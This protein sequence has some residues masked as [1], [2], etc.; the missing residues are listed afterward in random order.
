MVG[1]GASSAGAMRLPGAHHRVALDGAQPERIAA[2][3]DPDI[4]QRWFTRALSSTDI[5]VVLD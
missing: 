4:L 2:C 1:P 5:A 3:K